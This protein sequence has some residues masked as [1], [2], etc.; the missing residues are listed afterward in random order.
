MRLRHA[1]IASLL[2]LVP[3]VVLA[4]PPTSNV[5]DNGTVKSIEFQTS[6]TEIGGLT[7]GDIGGD[8]IKEIILSAGKGEKPLVAI[9]RQDGSIITEFL[10]YAE[11][12]DRGVSVSIGDID[13]DGQLEI[14]TGTQYGGGP[15]VRVFDTFGKVESEFFAYAKHFRGGVTVAL[16]DID[17][18]GIQEIA[19]APG[20]TGGP[21]VRV[22]SKD[23]TIINERFVFDANDRAGISIT[24]LDK[25]HD[26]RD[27]LVVTHLGNSIPEARIIFFDS[28][29]LA[30]LDE[31]FNIYGTSFQHGVTLFP[32]SDTTFG[33]VPNGHGGPHVRIFSPNGKSIFDWFAYESNMRDRILITALSSNNIFSVRTSPL[34]QK[35]LDKHI[36]VDVDDQH[37]YA[38]EDGI[39]LNDFPISSARW[40]FKTP[41]GE[42][43]VLRKLRW[44]DYV[45]TYGVDDPRNYN[46]PDVEY[47]LEFTRRYYIHH[48]YWHNNFG[49]PMSHGCVN[50]PY[51]GVKWLYDWAEVGTT[52]VVP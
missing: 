24:R 44:H 50:A 27:E 3:G 10:A 5:Y 22:F 13:G 8:G 45:W 9:A 41:R 31:P 12:Y 34:L 39:T 35:R 48:A 52:V 47:N 40:P 42:F 23:G 37:L 7:S 6:F 30:V 51:E 4:A 46:L 19:T 36:F 33:T 32:V 28:T 14:V 15:H 17:G 1:L 21:H 38:K 2:F 11:T 29:G 16:A 49:N 25:N 18:D 43:S 26:N 20:L